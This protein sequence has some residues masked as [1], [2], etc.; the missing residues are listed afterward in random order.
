MIKYN[1]NEYMLGRERV[2]GDLVFE[3]FRKVTEEQGVA[4]DTDKCRHIVIGFLSKVAHNLYLEP[5]KYLDMGMFVLYRSENLYNLITMQA[6]TGEN[7]Q[8]IKNYV[9]NG[10]L[11]G[12]DIQKLVKTFAG[13]LL[14]D[15]IERETKATETITKLTSL[16]KKRKRNKTDKEKTDGV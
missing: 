12:A 11:Y 14:E 13:E 8:S 5:E 15:S 9:D 6:K 2:E 16:S 4:I 1:K 3:L 10:G 7:A